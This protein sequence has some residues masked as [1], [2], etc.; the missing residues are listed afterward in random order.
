MRRNS[1]VSLPAHQAQ[2]AA[3]DRTGTQHKPV[4]SSILVRI[5]ELDPTSGATV[6]GVNGNRL[7]GLM[8]H[9]K[10]PFT[11]RSLLITSNDEIADFYKFLAKKMIKDLDYGADTMV[12]TRMCG[13][14]RCFEE[15]GNR[16]KRCSRCLI[17]Y[18]CSSECQ[19]S[20]WP[21]HQHVCNPAVK[22]YAA[23]NVQCHASHQCKVK[24]LASTFCAFKLPIKS[25]TAFVLHPS[26]ALRELDAQSSC[27]FCT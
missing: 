9:L 19:R 15:E 24:P 17:E 13:G 4:R 11:L 23:T 6:L 25:K 27:S 5:I 8:S 21:D 20:V 7:C 3:A 12:M 22:Q 10:R 2:S 14:C 16:M 26:A 1:H 18:Y